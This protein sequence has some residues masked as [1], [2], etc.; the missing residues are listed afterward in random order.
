MRRN[1]IVTAQ[2]AATVLLAGL[3]GCAAA[4][5]Q[6]KKPPTVSQ[7]RRQ[8]E[9]DTPADHL[10]AAV[11]L[12]TRGKS[13]AKALPD[14]LKAVQTHEGNVRSEAARAIGHIGKPAAR[15][16]SRVLRSGKGTQVDAALLAVPHLQELPAKLMPTME[17]LWLR[18]KHR[19]NEAVGDAFVGL[20]KRAVPFLTEA[21]D[22]RGVDSHIC[23]VLERIGP[24]AKPALPRLIQLLHSKELSNYKAAAPIAR[25]GDTAAIPALIQ[26]L[27]R[28]TEDQDDHLASTSA[29]ALGS[30]GPLAKK[31]VPILLESMDRR[32]ATGSSR[33][34][35]EAATALQ[36]IGANSSKVLQR[37]ERASRASVKELPEAAKEAVLGLTLPK[38]APRSTVYQALKHKDSRIRLTALERVVER[39][40]KMQNYTKLVSRMARQDKDIGVRQAALVTLG[41]IGKLDEH[42]LLALS[43]AEAGADKEI[44]AQARKW[45]LR[46]S[47]CR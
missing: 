23:R 12:G 24:D 31:A 2:A 36:W 8:L 45:T 34:R 33:H 3:M 20:G 9:A 47:P 19:L 42:V 17:R 40:D 38:N 1:R 29:R 25:I 44:A 6:T 39:A 22:R 41:A 7:L 28:A 4:S 37:L 10:A 32:T 35:A 5:A 21:M 30:F 43:E 18:E 16:V 46:Y 26:A 27:E 15:F 11:A 13:A 14:L